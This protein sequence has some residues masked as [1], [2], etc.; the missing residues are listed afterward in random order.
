MVTTCPS[1]NASYDLADNQDCPWCRNKPTASESGRFAT[2]RSCGK[3]FNRANE[4]CPF[5]LTP[6][7]APQEKAVE[8]LS[9]DP[10]L[11]E[12]QTSREQ[13]TVGEMRN[14]LYWTGIQWIV[15]PASNHGS[16]A[17]A[18]YLKAVLLVVIANIVASLGGFLAIVNEETSVLVLPG[19]IALA[20]ML[21]A[22]IC[23]IQG[24][25]ALTRARLSLRSSTPPAR[26]S[27]SSPRRSR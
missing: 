4:M 17:A 14:G 3:N 10:P 24:G 8:V 12:A 7:P 1:C 11:T 9:S 21:W 15:M 23:F 27:S 18:Y 13:F 16:I 20:L 26:D 19:L 6:L 25:G 5:C 22:F 2:C